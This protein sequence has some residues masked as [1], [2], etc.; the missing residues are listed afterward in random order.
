MG[1]TFQRADVPSPPSFSKRSG[2]STSASKSAGDSCAMR[3]AT[4]KPT[5]ARR[6]AQKGAARGGH[7]TLSTHAP[8][9]K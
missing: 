6:R 1:A 9:E 4:A 8:S 7:T 3:S 5:V 2:V